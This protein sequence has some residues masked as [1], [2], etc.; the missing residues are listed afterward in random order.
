[1]SSSSTSYSISSNASVGTVL[2]GKGGLLY[3][4]AKLTGPAGFPAARCTK[5]MKGVPL[6]SR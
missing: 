3:L 5:A 4:E 1:M 6:C 2:S